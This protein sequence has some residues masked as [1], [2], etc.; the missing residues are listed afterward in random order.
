ME[1]MHTSTGNYKVKLM[2][3]SSA[4]KELEYAAEPTFSTIVKDMKDALG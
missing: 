1:T 2:E 3:D 4:I